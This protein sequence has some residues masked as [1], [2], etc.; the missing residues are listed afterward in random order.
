MTGLQKPQHSAFAEIA[1]EVL[2][3]TGEDYSAEIIELIEH[4]QKDPY[5]VS[6]LCMILGFYKNDRSPKLLWDYYH[7]FKEHF[8]AETYSDGP[9]VALEEMRAR[10]KE[11]L[12]KIKR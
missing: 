2:H 4:Y 6:L 3:A 12:Q 8:P 11:E 9:L 1:I 7:Y 5:I 10:K